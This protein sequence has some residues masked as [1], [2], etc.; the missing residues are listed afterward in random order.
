MSSP[1]DPEGIGEA[2]SERPSFTPPADPP[3]AAWQPPHPDARFVD[4]P[5][6]GRRPRHPRGRRIAIA[7]VLAVALL[8]TGML[9]MLPLLSPGPSAP[10]VAGPPG[11]VTASPSPRAT[12]ASTAAGGGLSSPVAFTGPSGSG[13]ITVTKAVWTDGGRIAPPSGQRYLVLDVT[14]A[15]TGGTLPVTPELLLLTGTASELPGYGPA[16][17]RPLGSR[18][19]RAGEDAAGQ[20]GYVLSPGAVRLEVLDENLRRLAAVEVPAP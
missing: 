12:T 6:E 9:S 1:A 14:I 10:P 20:V 4:V 15:C 2:S 5:P 18:L 16:L 11:L 8:M 19:L 3:P 7:G 17:D 13:T